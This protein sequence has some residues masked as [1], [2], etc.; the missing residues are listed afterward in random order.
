MIL[1]SKQDLWVKNVS[2]LFYN[3]TGKPHDS[4]CVN[5][6]LEHAREGRDE[7]DR[8]TLAGCTCNAKVIPLCRDT[9]ALNILCRAH[10][11]GTFYWLRLKDGWLSRELTWCRVTRSFSLRS[12]I[13]YHP[14]SLSIVSYA[15]VHTCASSQLIDSWN[16]T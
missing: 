4:Q 6:V 8:K 11:G 16:P 10:F 1:I 9:I 13:V 12:T 15:H 5:N 7:R 3:V 14:P 2:D